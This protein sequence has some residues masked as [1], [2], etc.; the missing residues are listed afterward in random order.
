MDFGLCAEPQPAAPSPPAQGAWRTVTE[1]DGNARADAQHARFTAIISGR[2]QGVG[3]RVYAQRQALDLGLSGYAEN[4][5]DGRVEVVAEGELGDLRHFLHKL[6][7][8]PPHSL[9]DD[10]E[11]SWSEPGEVEGFYVY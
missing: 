6:K 5:A 11:V 2:V 8:G 1:R 7:R 4:L 10:V 3:F 9:V